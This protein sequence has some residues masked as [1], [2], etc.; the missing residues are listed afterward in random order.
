MPERQAQTFP[1]FGTRLARNLHRAP[2]PSHHTEDC[3]LA[4]QHGPMCGIFQLC[5]SVWRGWNG[6]ST[7]HFTPIAPL[8]KTTVWFESARSYPEMTPIAASSSRPHVAA[9]QHDS[10]NS[11]EMPSSDNLASVVPFSPCKNRIAHMHANGRGIYQRFLRL[12]LN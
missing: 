12:C 7:R 6:S 4:R 9:A 1:S 3:L 8:G 2:R 11:I 10:D 5:A